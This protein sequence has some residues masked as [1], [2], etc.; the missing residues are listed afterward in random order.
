MNENKALE[1]NVT[2]EAIVPEAA[3]EETVA[4]PEGAPAVVQMVALTEEAEALP[5]MPAVEAMAEPVIT[6]QPEAEPAAG[7]EEA[8]A[9]GSGSGRC[10][11]GFSGCGCGEYS[12]GEEASAGD[13]VD[14]L[15]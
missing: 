11:S 15:D 8:P 13:S 9:V 1:E 6:T 12:A 4:A 2:P 14:A 5:A 3:A 7:V 10:G